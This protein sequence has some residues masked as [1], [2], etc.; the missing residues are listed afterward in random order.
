MNRLSGNRSSCKKN[1]NRVQKMSKSSSEL[2]L[3]FERIGLS[4]GGGIQPTLGLLQS[5]VD[6][7][8]RAI[9][10]E[11]LDVLLGVSIE[12]EVPALVDKLLI[13]RRGGYCFE[14]NALLLHML[15]KL[16]YRVQPLS[17][18]VLWQLPVSTTPARSHLFLR[19]ELE[20]ASWLV[21]VGMGGLS[22]TGALRLLVDKRQETPH[23]PRRLVVRETTEM[24]LRDEP[25]RV[26]VH[27]V[28]FSNAWHDVYEFTLEAMPEIDRTVANWYTSAHPGSHFRNRLIASRA[29]RGGRLTLLNRQLT[30]RTTNGE[31]MVRTMTSPEEL[32]DVL[33]RKFDLRMPP[34]TQFRCEALDW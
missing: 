16:G 10:F 18:R 5:I 21:D 29:F 3:Y 7:H 23:E 27:Q 12:L 24:P 6:A 28:F 22:P 30:R 26:F 32:L 33:K 13:R 11:N 4:G 8:I 1:P 14:Q 34:G 15:V 25:T 2:Q 17:A 20:G 31:A 19:V 9:P